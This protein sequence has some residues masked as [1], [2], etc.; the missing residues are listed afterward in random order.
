MSTLR[1]S[2]ISNLGGTKDATTNDIS[3]V[4][5][6]ND[7]AYAQ[8]NKIAG[9]TMAVGFDTILLDEVTV[10]KNITLTSNLIYFAI[11][12]VYHIDLGFRFGTAGDIWTGARLWSSTAGEVGKSF[13]T[14]NVNN[15]PGPAMF[16][17][18]ANIT[19]TSVGYALQTYRA[20]GTM[21]VA[22]PDTNAGRAFVSTIVKVS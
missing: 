19:N 4:A 22:T 5:D 7:I 10:S 6:R 8:I 2:N 18:L 1:V 17:F 12:G 20:S 3:D 9:Q 11:A 14:G 16:S 13:G 21:G 15:D